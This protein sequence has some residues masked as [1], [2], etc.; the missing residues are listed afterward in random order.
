MDTTGSAGV[1]ARD[2]AAIDRAIAIGVAAGRVISVSF[3][4]ETPDDASDDHE[5]LDRI[6]ASLE[7]EADALDDVAVAL[8][9]PTDQRAV[10]DAL[11]EIPRGET[12]SVSRLTRL[13]GLDDNDPDDLALVTTALDENPVPL[14]LPDHRVDGGP[15]ATPAGVRDAL[16][17]A[18]GI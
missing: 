9:V 8:T 2:V 13:A 5:L 3:P 15:Y 18:E 11:G 10:L 4:A 12:V 7:G 1:F 6:E 14:L 16:R 17:R